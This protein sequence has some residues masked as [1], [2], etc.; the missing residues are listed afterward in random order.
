MGAGGHKRIG[1]VMATA[2]YHIHR[3]LGGGFYEGRIK[4]ETRQFPLDGWHLRVVR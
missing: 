2:Q 3:L 4:G 1:C